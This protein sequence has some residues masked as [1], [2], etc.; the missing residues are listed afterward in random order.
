VS[1]ASMDDEELCSTFDVLLHE[2]LLEVYRR[3]K[4]LVVQLRDGV[5]TFHLADA[6]V[7][8]GHGDTVMAVG[9][10]DDPPWSRGG[11]LP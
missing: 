7:G 8:N 5:L 6:A 2:A 3:K 11:K 4:T 1:I 10:A 9:F